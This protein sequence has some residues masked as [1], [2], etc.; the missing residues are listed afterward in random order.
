MSHDHNNT[1]NEFLFSANMKKQ[2]VNEDASFDESEFSE[3]YG[4]LRVEKREGLNSQLEGFA[5]WIRKLVG[6]RVVG[7][8]F[9]Y[10]T[11][12]YFQVWADANSVKH[13]A[14]TNLCLVY[15]DSA[16]A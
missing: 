11:K 10:S 13:T 16:F 6:G 9:A 7:A 8:K 12:L 15:M 14:I 5:I 3:Q 2:N 4:K 1:S